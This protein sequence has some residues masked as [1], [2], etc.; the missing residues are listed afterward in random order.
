MCIAINSPKGTTPKKESLKES[1][2]NNPHGG[3]FAFVDDGK[4][5]IKK[6]FMDFNKFFRAYNDANLQSKNK[7]IHFRIKTS[8]KINYENCHPFMV[9]DKLAMIHN[10]VIP[11]FG[12]D[13][14]SDTREFISMVLA[15]IIKENGLEV[16][17]NQTFIETM[18]DLIGSSKLVFLDNKGKSYIINETLG[19]Y[20]CD[21]WFS[22]SSY[23]SYNTDTIGNYKSYYNESYYFDDVNCDECGMILD[24]SFDGSICEFC[25]EENERKA[26]QRWYFHRN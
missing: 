19:H 2:K 3:G 7:L 22:N 20:N 11:N 8:G 4:I 25:T 12:N 17:T 5:I 16:L 24:T 23:K 21:V 6:G 15:P 9:T 10:G 18:R 14:I 26:P 13:K 1:F